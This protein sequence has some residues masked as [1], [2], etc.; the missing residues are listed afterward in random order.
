M[1]ENWNGVASV[2]FEPIKRDSLPRKINMLA[3]QIRAFGGSHAGQSHEFDE[4]GGNP[5]LSIEALSA[6]V[7]DQGPKLTPSWSRANG[8]LHPQALE[9]GRWGRGDDAELQ[10]KLEKLTQK[11][12]IFV[13]SGILE[14][15]APAGEPQLKPSGADRMNWNIE[16]VR[17]ALFE[18][19]EDRSPRGNGL[20]RI[21]P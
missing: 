18:D 20:R 5:R 15:R 6:N 7:R 9:R 16:P 19:F 1:G 8:C 2:C 17:P 3:H 12:R 14:I 21:L 10:G 4:V 13:V 11:P